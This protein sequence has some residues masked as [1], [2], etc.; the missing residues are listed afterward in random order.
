MLALA[1]AEPIV[2]AER[3]G[4]QSFAYVLQADKFASAKAAAVERL[5]GC[6]RDLIVLDVAYTADSAWTM[7]ELRQIRDGKTGRKVVAYVSIG[8]A[9]D[10]RPYWRR[11]WTD[12]GKRPTAEAPAFLGPS[13]PDWPGNYRVKYWNAQWQA[14]IRETIFS[15]VAQGFDG[16]YMDIVDGFEFFEFDPAKKDYIDDRRNPETGNTYRQD[17]IHWV[18]SIA[19]HARSKA[20]QQFLVIPQNASQLLAN[21]SYLQT[22]SAIGVEDLFT[23][24]NKKQPKRTVN[25][26]VRDLQAA[27]KADKPV[28]VIEYGTQ[29]QAQAVSRAGAQ[30][31]G[32]VLLLTDRPLTGRDLKSA[33]S[34]KP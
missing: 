1:A 15:V 27:K 19:E 24:G 30:E 21:P 10:Y 6:D 33:S 8:E 2:A 4:P 22:I 26:R 29:E 31:H 7:S 13:N 3:F 18:L 11:A 28:L 32:F 12:N 17:M 34:H 5:A 20:G 25:E 23:N 14:I 9:E 16:I